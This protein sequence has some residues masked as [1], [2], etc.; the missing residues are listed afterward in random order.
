MKFFYEVTGDSPEAV[1][2]TI[3]PSDGSNAIVMTG[4]ANQTILNGDL[5]NRVCL[6]TTDN[7]YKS[8]SIDFYS[9]DK[10]HIMELALKSE[11]YELHSKLI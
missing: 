1:K 7:K 6:L 10:A 2:V 3:T 11:I 5:G 9:H 4:S 8:I